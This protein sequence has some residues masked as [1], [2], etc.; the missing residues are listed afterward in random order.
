VR[1][2]GSV[3]ETDLRNLSD[4]D[5]IIAQALD[6]FMLVE[7]LPTPKL[8]LVHTHFGFEPEWLAREAA[9]QTLNLRR[10]LQE[11]PIVYV[12]LYCEDNW[13]P[14]GRIIRHGIDR[15]DYVA[16]RWR[17]KTPRVLTG[18]HFF[19]ERAEFTGYE[20]PRR[21]VADDIPFKIVGYNPKLPTPG[22]RPPGTSCGG[23]TRTTVST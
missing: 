2:I 12:S 4:Y 19:C 14:P 10:R 13:G 20:M 17:G 9:L 8:L 11:V 16:Y 21:V 23:V 3:A 6:Q 1:V 18:S 7:F 15:R 22:R 5:L